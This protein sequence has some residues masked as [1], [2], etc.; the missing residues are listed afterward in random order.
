MDR[1]NS[2]NTLSQV[3]CKAAV[4]PY[5]KY[6]SYINLLYMFFIQTLLLVMIKLLINFNNDL[7]INSFKCLT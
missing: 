3:T 7:L 4:I 6:S 5:A 2:K 1:H